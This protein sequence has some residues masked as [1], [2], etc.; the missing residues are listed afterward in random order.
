MRSVPSDWGDLM[1]PPAARWTTV[2]VMLTVAAFAAPAGAQARDVLSAFHTSA[3]WGIEAGGPGLSA[4][5]QPTPLEVTYDANP[6]TKDAHQEDLPVVRGA[7]AK[8]APRDHGFVG[9][10]SVSPT[11][12]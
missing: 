8:V 6:V 3:G 5:R 4:V 12:G 2:L 10:G 11:S 1:H 9:T 7:Y